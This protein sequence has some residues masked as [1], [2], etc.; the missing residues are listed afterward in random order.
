MA[1]SDLPRLPSPRPPHP[2]PLR[3]A[4]GSEWIIAALGRLVAWLG[5][6][7]VLLTFVVVLL[8]Y[9]FAIGSVALQEAIVYL[10]ATLFMLG[11]AYTLQRDAHVRVDLFYRRL[12]RRGQAWV[13]LLGTLVLLVPLCLFV[14]FSSFGYVSD[15]WAI[16]EGSR[17]AGGLPWVWLLKT[18]LLVMPVLV[19][20]QGGAWGVRNA[21]Y[22]AGVTAA[23]P[24]VAGGAL[25]SERDG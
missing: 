21:L 5:L 16:R 1:E 10:H 7:M 18:L 22:L 23:L 24:T 12:S 14:L 2:W 19:L 8:R 17:E 9:G 20:L 25:T 6:V 4:A 13:D 3:L 15:A 11:V